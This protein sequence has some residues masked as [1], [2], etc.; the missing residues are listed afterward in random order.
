M[1]YS[2]QDLYKNISFETVWN[3]GTAG[4]IKLDFGYE[5]VNFVERDK[6]K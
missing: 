2:L 6:G 1:P 4:G 5:M 3:F